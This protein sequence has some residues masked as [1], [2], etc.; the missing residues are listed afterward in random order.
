VIR[1]APAALDLVQ[2]RE[3]PLPDGLVRL[4]LRDELRHFQL[5]LQT[6]I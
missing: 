1:A 6:F 4:P 2:R 5:S 3:Q